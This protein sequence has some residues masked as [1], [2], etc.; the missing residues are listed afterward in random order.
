ML[1][2]AMMLIFMLAL[3]GCSPEYFS[4]AA[5]NELFPKRYLLTQT[6][7]SLFLR[8]AMMYR[9]REDLLRRVRKHTGILSL[10]VYCTR[11]NWEISITV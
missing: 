5:A 6:L 1:E 2:K 7:R 9:K 4:E 3:T 10:T 8:A 11:R